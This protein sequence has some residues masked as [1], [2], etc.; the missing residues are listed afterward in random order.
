MLIL[1]HCTALGKTCHD[2]ER[3]P[4]I[5]N[6]QKTAVKRAV[7]RGLGMKWK[8]FSNVLKLLVYSKESLIQTN[9]NSFLYSSQ[10]SDVYGDL[11]KEATSPSIKASIDDALKNGRGHCMSLDILTFVRHL[12][13]NFNEHERGGKIGKDW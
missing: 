6:R 5:S 13:R 1:P 7:V 10:C 3:H 2:D 9:G 4:L 12:E 11:S 8:C